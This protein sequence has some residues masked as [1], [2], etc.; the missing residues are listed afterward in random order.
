MYFLSDQWEKDERMMEES[1]KEM[2]KRKPVVILDSR[3]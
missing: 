3:I 1:E 2:N